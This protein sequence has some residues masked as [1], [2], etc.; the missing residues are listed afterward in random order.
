MRRK[1][2]MNVS[3]ILCSARQ[4]ELPMDGVGA[5]MLDQRHI[6][7]DHVLAASRADMLSIEHPNAGLAQPRIGKPH[8]FSGA[9]E[10]RNEG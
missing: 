9:T 10:L 5:K 1:F 2:L 7:L 8:P 4:G 3:I 6:H